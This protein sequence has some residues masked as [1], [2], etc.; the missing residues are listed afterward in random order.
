[1]KRS[2]A[3]RYKR[4]RRKFE[5]REAL[6]MRAYRALEWLDGEHGGVSLI[7]YELAEPMK[8]ACLRQIEEGR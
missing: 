5:R 3:D 4:M 1:M 2:L 6:F 8:L 7:P